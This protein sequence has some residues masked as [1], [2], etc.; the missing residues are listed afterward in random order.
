MGVMGVEKWLHKRLMLCG[1]FAFPM[2]STRNKPLFWR[3]VMN[4]VRQFV[5]TAENKMS[6]SFL[7]W[8][9]YVLVWGLSRALFLAVS[10]PICSLIVNTHPSLQTLSGEREAIQ[11][12]QLGTVA[13][14]A[15]FILPTAFAQAH[16]RVSF[17][18]LLP[19]K[20]V[21]AR[22]VM[23]LLKV[24]EI[25]MSSLLLSLSMNASC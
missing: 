1:C 4:C 21:L 13:I 18:F 16:A 9:S 20:T 7:S 25:D 11:F 17:F 8:F 2:T 12:A 10:N 23:C 3:G 5:C 6:C 19:W 22:H 15:R 24:N 14:L